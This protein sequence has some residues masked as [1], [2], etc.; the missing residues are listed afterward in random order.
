MA[1]ATTAKLQ[2]KP[3]TP[4]QNFFA[5]GNYGKELPVKRTVLRNAE[6]GLSADISRRNPHHTGDFEIKAITQSKLDLSNYNP[7]AYLRPFEQKR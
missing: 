1:T 5:T 7:A 4:L 2:M 3:N 6:P